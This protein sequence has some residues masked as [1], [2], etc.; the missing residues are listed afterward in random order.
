M[1][2][3]D[4]VLRVVQRRRGMS[5]DLR[6]LLREGADLHQA[7]LARALDVSPAAVSRWESG[8]R[9]PQGKAGEAYLDFLDRL[10]R[11]VLS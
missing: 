6:R 4:D 3:E 2:D 9:R 11:E 10:A 1:A 5:P 8:K 7:D